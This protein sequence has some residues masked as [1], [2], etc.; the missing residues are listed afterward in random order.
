MSQPSA[1][2]LTAPFPSGP[3]T[4]YFH[5][6]KEKRWTLDTFKPIAKVNTIQDLLTIFQELGDKLKR[7]MYFCM[8]DPIPPL[9][10]N[11]QNIRGGSYSLR[12]GS[13]DG[14][15]YFKTYVVG[16][17]TNNITLNPKDTI[18]GISVSPKV[19]NGPNGTSKIG[20][21]VIKIW[22]QDCQT[23]HDT[24]G[25]RLLHP[26]LVLGDILYTPHV[27]KKM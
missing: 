3:W 17:M 5:A 16:A 8:K 13:E 18:V 25:I 11:Y 20:F 21:Y 6:P 2:S 9:W 23:F 12:G 22:N 1:I 15:D 4:F 14:I 10:E 7:G 26:K 24:R 27:D 19:M